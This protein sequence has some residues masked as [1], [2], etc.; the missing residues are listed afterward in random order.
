MANK[1]LQHQPNVFSWDIQIAHKKYWIRV[2]S[3]DE[4]VENLG[5]CENTA[6][7]IYVSANPYTIM[8][9]L[10]HELIHA[11]CFVHTQIS[12]YSSDEFGIGLSIAFEHWF[13]KAQDVIDLYS[14]ISKHIT[15]PT[16]VKLNEERS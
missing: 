3:Y 11:Y 10:K 2:V 13:N 8:D 7:T 12:F 4:D 1:L 16:M 5:W 9:T 6:R 14:H 15:D